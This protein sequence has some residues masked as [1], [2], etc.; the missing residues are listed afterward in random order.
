MCV[1]VETMASLESGGGDRSLNLCP[2]RVPSRES[3]IL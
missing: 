3:S 2:D 1:C